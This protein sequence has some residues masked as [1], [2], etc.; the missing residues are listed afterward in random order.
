MTICGSL[1]IVPRTK[2]ASIHIPATILLPIKSDIWY[3]LVLYTFL[4]V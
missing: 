4:P 1:A 2:I 3:A